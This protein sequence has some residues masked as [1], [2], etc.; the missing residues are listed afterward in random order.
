MET[1]Y[2]Y[3]TIG[4]RNINVGSSVSRPGTGRKRHGH[5][6]GEKDPGVSE[7]ADTGGNED[8]LISQFSP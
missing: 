8:R 2:G 6:T 3:Q 5:D 4:R 1:G 7:L